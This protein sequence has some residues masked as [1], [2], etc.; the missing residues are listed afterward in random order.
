VAGKTGTLTDYKQN[1][2]YTWFVGFA[3]AEAPEIAISTLVVN[4]PSWQIKAPQLARDVLRTYFEKKSSST[5]D[6]VA[7]AEPPPNP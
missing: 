4:T 5:S 6:R 3:P 7:R 2:F 1:R